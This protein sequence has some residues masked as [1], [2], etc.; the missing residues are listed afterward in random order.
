[1][2]D[3][4]QLFLRPLEVEIES[5]SFHFE[6]RAVDMFVYIGIMLALHPHTQR[7]RSNNLRSQ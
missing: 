5:L 6:H 4:N 7:G 3:L 1:M 2:L